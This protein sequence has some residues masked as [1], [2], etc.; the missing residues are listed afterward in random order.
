VWKALQIASY[1]VVPM[2]WGLFVEF[3]FEQ[4]RR[5]SSGAGN[6]GGEA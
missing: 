3:I 4:L 1:V 6:E 2:A 5:R